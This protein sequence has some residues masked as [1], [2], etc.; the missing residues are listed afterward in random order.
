V[1]LDATGDALL[2]TALTAVR[3]AV[4]APGGA[5]AERIA[6]VA[7]DVAGSP[8]QRR[9]WDALRAIPAGETRSYG[10]VAA[11][12]GAPKAARAVARACAT[13]RV[14]L[15]VPCHRVV[16]GEG[17]SGGYR[18]GEARKRALLERE[19]A[20]ARGASRSGSVHGG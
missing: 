7:L 3:A 12:L 10:A 6:A 8:F 11:S 16:R 20:A 5:A 15:L 4:D 18:W 14:A 13:N 2:A 19:R 1:D 9:V 17:T